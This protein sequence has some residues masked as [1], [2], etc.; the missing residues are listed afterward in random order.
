MGM[1]PCS[2][3]RMGRSNAVEQPP[4]PSAPLVCTRYD[5]DN[6][7]P[8]KAAPNRKYCS[9]RCSNTVRQ[10]RAAKSRK[11]KLDEQ[12]KA[13][14][15]QRLNEAMSK[16]G[17]GSMRRGPE[18]EAFVKA[19][20][21]AMLD[22]RG[23][24]RM[25]HEEV[26]EV[27]GVSRVTIT[28]WMAAYAQDM[29]V[30]QQRQAWAKPEEAVKATEDFRAFRARYF[31]IAR[32]KYKGKPPATT[33][34]H[35]RWITAILHALET[36]GQL[37]VLSPPR[38]GK[39]LLMAHF[40]IWLIVRNPDIAILWVSG[41]EGIARRFGSLVRDELE[42][43]EL[44]I[45]DFCGPGGSFMPQTR[46]G[47]QWRDDE[48]EVATRTIPQPAPT[49][50]AIGKGG[51]SLSMDADA[52]IVD[53]IED[54]QSTIQPAQR[55]STRGWFN[56]D[57]AS[58][59]E[60]HTG[61]VYIGSRQ[62]PEDLASH[63]LVSD[64]W[65]CIVESAHDADC[66]IPLDEESRHVDCVLWP[67]VRSFKY[68]MQKLRTVGAHI[69]DMQYLNRPRSEGM[70]IFERPVV[71]ECR[72]FSRVLGDVPPHTRLI[73]GIDPSGSSK[74]GYQG[75]ILWAVH[76]ETNTRFLVDIENEP[77]GGVVHLRS[78]LERWTMRYQLHEWAIEHNIIEDTLANDKPLRD[79]KDRLNPVI[80]RHIT[81]R[82]KWDERMGVPKTAEHFKAGRINL[83][84]GDAETREKVEQYIHQLVNF[85]TNVSSHRATYKTDLVMAG[86]VPEKVI[87]G[88]QQ[89]Y[90]ADMQVD[91]A[92][93]GI[94]EWRTDLDDA[95]WGS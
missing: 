43:N 94:R 42:H 81:G 89:D 88:W 35:M 40:V 13:A 65:E 45:N 27:F 68:L 30:E 8:G 9:P 77:H 62:H 95:P 2:L 69:F 83:P 67:E 70:T 22:D 37:M 76:V 53:D 55:E 85:T 1:T 20:G 49:F 59:K 38:H 86:W 34:F 60:E 24:G 32:G 47:A 93:S 18:Y 72:D 17:R 6:P 4:V 14:N 21:P 90:I 10:R 87:M 75:A 5:C 54:Y 29:R 44:L 91:Y 52:I 73:A 28:H 61:W 63:L 31:K 51:K 84:Y 78:I 39:S 7:I 66:A 12:A 80:H 16:D 82:N 74:S 71:E 33:D 25:T 92:Q 26:A 19:G 58:R 48:F 11:A 46:S 36:G 3:L 64:E 56:S 15:L 23:H 41:N 79:L 57:L 50:K